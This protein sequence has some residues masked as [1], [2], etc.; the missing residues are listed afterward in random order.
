MPRRLIVPPRKLIPVVYSRRREKKADCM[1]LVKPKYKYAVIAPIMAA[2]SVLNVR[3]TA[4]APSKLG[5]SLLKTK[6]KSPVGKTHMT[7][8]ATK[9]QKKVRLVV[10]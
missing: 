3:I 9:S 2:M 7:K 6:A 1:L 8:G 4:D 10:K 5:I